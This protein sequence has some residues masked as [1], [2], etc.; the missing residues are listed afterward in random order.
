MLL[1][2][3]DRRKGWLAAAALAAIAVVN[4]KLDSGFGWAFLDIAAAFALVSAFYPLW[5][6]GAA[7]ESGARKTIVANLIG[8]F[9]VLACGET[10]IRIIAPQAHMSPRLVASPL[11]G[12]AAPPQT[13]FVNSKPGHWRFR[14]STNEYGHRGPAAPAASAY[15]APHVVLLGD[16]YTFGV[17]VDDGQEYAAV[18]AAALGDAAKIVNLGSPGWGLTQE[19]RRFYEFGRVYDPSVVML[20]FCENDPGDDVQAPVSYFDG[21]RIVFRSLSDGEYLLRKNVQALVRYLGESVLQYSQV[22]EIFRYGVF[23]FMRRRFAGATGG[24]GAPEIEQDNL[25]NTLLE[26]FADDLFR[27]G[28]RLVFFSVDGEWGLAPHPLIREK[29]LALQAQGKLLFVDTE[30]L[31]VG[32]TGYDSPEGHHWGVSGHKIIGKAMARRIGELLRK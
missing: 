15:G 14:Y 20:Q 10:A 6:T 23:E 18:M 24:S 13:D 21:G 11:Y 19:I 31:F 17:G 8:V 22:Y 3:L 4:F 32:E 25:Y 29:A 16:S 5:L 9:V 27:R 7:A 2:P 12:M 28:I 1:F 30:P 26:A